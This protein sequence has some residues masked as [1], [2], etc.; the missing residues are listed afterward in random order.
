MNVLILTVQRVLSVLVRT[1]HEN[2]LKT[3]FQ[4]YFHFIEMRI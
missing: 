1:W 4:V 3:R 2:F